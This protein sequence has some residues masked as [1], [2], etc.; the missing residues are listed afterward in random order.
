MLALRGIP[1][2]P[3]LPVCVDCDIDFWGFW[4]LTFAM[5]DDF[6]RAR[7]EHMIDLRHPLAVLAARMPWDSNEASL[8]PLFARH[9]RPGKQE[10]DVDLFGPAVVVVSGGVSHR[11]AS[12]AAHS[13]HGLAAVLEARLQHER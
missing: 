5:I 11:R 7:I 12:A 13:A 3:K 8:L 9:N 10:G 4:L 2:H 6:F 1:C